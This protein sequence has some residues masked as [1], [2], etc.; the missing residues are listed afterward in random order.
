M[1]EDGT[2]GQHMRAFKEG[3]QRCEANGECRE[4]DVP[5]HNPCELDTGQELGVKTHRPRSP[6]HALRATPQNVA[7]ASARLRAYHRPKKRDSEDNI[8]PFWLRGCQYCKHDGWRRWNA[9]GQRFR[10]SACA[11]RVWRFD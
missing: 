2:L 6:R 8:C 1:E 9:A 3:D 5:T 10:P 4:Q 7:N 11:A